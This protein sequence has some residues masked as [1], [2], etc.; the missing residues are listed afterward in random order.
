[1]KITGYKDVVFG[2]GFYY[3]DATLV[4]TTPLILRPIRFMV[5]TGCQITTVSP[6]D[7]L[8]FNSVIPRPDIITTGAGGSSI[9]TSS[10]ANCGLVFDLVQSIHLEKLSKVNFLMPNMTPQNY[11]TVMK[12]PS[13][14][15]MDIL[16]RY[17]LEFNSVSVTL[18]K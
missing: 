12:L 16:S 4:S 3:I 10:L 17:Y 18:E 15:G 14:L 2:T 5:D 9:P 13:V 11:G 1:L 8:P 6:K 7:Y